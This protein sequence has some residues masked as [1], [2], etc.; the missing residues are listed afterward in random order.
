MYSGMGLPSPRHISWTESPSRTQP[1][2]V[3]GLSTQ[4]C[5]CS[6]GSEGEAGRTGQYE[7][8]GPSLVQDALQSLV[9][10]FPECYWEAGGTCQ[11]SGGIRVTH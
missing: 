10:K 7:I 6:V 5:T 9:V 2:V 1:S 11:K 3:D 4:N 8:W